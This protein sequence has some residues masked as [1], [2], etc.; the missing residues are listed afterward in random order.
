M[1]D[2]VLVTEH[3]GW[4]EIT[5][6]R[7]DKLNSFNEEMHLAL[8]AALEAAVQNGAR[9][10]LLTGAGRGFCAGQD[11]GDRDPAKL[12]GPPDLSRTLTQF[13]NPLVRFLKNAEIP[14]VCAVNGV[15]AGAG[16]NIA[17]A[18]DLVLASNK[19]K[20]VQSFSKVGLIPD[21]GGTWTLT[22]L[23]GVA[24]S[25][26]LAMTAAPIDAQRAENWGLIY[27]CVP[28]EQ[29]MEEARQLTEQLSKGPTQ[30][31]KHIKQAI[32]AATENTF[33]EQ[34]DLE[35]RLQKVCGESPDYSEGVSAFLA[36]RQPNF[37]GDVS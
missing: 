32:H 9:A 4:V 21:S 24:R 8:K 11:L 36:K 25:K 27:Q 5:L 22:Q 18:C 28:A 14:I 2:T 3:D 37:S 7:P 10:L 30:G 15:A 1:S 31:Y 35:A 34:L 33:D 13:Y 19:A 29:L 6:N 23:L 16:A 26:A 20:F 17:L 12:D